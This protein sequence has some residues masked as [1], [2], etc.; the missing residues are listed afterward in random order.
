MTRRPPRSTLFPYPT[1]FRSRELERWGDGEPAHRSERDDEPQRHGELRDRHLHPDLYGGGERHPH[2]GAPT[3]R[4]IHR[5]RQAGGLTAPTP[6]PLS[7][8]RRPC[9]ATPP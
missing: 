6:P 4:Y 2:G 1:P 3:V 7:Q 9:A 8:P 5:D